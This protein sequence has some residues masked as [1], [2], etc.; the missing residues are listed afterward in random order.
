MMSSCVG[1]HEKLALACCSSNMHLGTAAEQE[2]ADT[3]TH[4]STLGVEKQGHQKRIFQWTDHI[5]LLQCH[6][7]AIQLFQPTQSTKNTKRPGHLNA[8]LSSLSALR[9]RARDAEQFLRTLR[10]I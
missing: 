10:D 9:P 5:R 1:E 4:R 7:V 3:T 2:E 6:I 8:G